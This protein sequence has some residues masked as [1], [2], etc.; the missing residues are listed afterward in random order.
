MKGVLVDSNIVLDV[1]L[2]DPK[3]AAWSESKLDEYDQL[4]I[5]YI[6]SI[7]YSEISI[8]FDRIED[9]ES[10]IARAGFQVLEIP[11]EALFLAG[12]AYLK[13]KKRKGIKRTP[14]PDFFIGAHAAVQ[15]LDLITRDVSRYHSYFPTVK[16]I[17]P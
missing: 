6:N 17:S 13:Y 11:K 2:N 7:V 5:L 16:L 12:K 10:A 3:W 9:L 8:G 14:L 4:G 1:F 15:N